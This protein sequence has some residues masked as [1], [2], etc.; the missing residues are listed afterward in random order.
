MEFISLQPKITKDFI[1]S[2]VNQ[3]SIMQYYT[4]SNVTSKKLVTSCLRN[5]NHV[6]V[7][8]YKSKSGILY[9][10]DFATNEHIDCWNLVMRLYNCNYYE[11]L[12]IIAQDFNL[13]NSNV[14]KS[15]SPKIV[16]SLKE[17]ESS[18]IQVQIKKYTDKELEWWKQ[19]GI[20]IKTLK[21]F[22]VFSLQH[23]FL[24]GELKFTSSEQCPIY[25][26]YFGKDKNGNEKW[27]C[28][29]PT[30]DSF[31][32]LNNLSKKV[33]QGYHQLPKTGELLVITKSMKDVCALYEFG[34][35]AVSPNS[36]TLFLDDKK[37]EEFKQ[38]FKHILVIYDN[39]RPGL[40][41][42]WL[43]RKQHPE[44]N[45]YFLPW[46]LS[47]DFTDSIKMVGVENMKEYVN[48]FMSSYTFK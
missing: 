46:Y 18:R 33:L 8:F 13:V 27:K 20:S 22:Q 10:H 31:R 26:Y 41:N 14:V 17:T 12:K 44:L 42:M 45:Y 1:L 21:K 32:F 29:F 2:K 34:I 36:E 35:P 16:E 5:D 30:R 25:G 23:I 19:F 28:Y 37:L 15:N 40:H 38:R 4:G 7:G 24:N 47:K 39:D 9:M 11:A 43:I 3:E 48:E 6:T